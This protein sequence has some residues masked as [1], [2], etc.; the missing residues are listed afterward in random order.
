MREGRSAGAAP[1]PPAPSAGAGP[2]TGS[3]SFP[4]PGALH[5]VLEA[6]ELL[7]VPVTATR[8]DVERAFRGRSLTC[9]P[10]KV[11]HLDEDFRELAERKFK[12]LV[13]AYRTLNEILPA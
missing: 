9:H 10:D 7:G 3:P 1:P 11:A 2:A 4:E 8:E 6:Y 13:E 12:R 5:G